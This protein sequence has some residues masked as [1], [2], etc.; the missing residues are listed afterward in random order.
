MTCKICGRGFPQRAT[1]V[2]LD[3][4]VMHRRCE[5]R[6][7]KKLSAKRSRLAQERSSRVKRKP[8]SER[9]AALVFQRDGGLCQICG[10]DLSRKR[11]VEWLDRFEPSVVIDLPR[12][13][14]GR[15]DRFTEAFV[16]G[17]LLGRHRA[18]ALVLLGRL[19]GVVLTRGCHFHE[20]DHVKPVAEGGRNELPNYRTLCRKC[21]RI[22]SMALN[23]RLRSRPSKAVGR[24]FQ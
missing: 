1:V 15:R 5:N 6:G 12:Y 2:L 17:A 19:W 4:E 10:F 21:H 20:I 13:V 3:G 24:G 8:I 22:E 23:D 14:E 7:Q 18:R 11:M 16:D 9:D